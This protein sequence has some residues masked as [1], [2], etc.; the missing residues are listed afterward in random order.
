MEPS[1]PR[2]RPHLVVTTPPEISRAAAPYDQRRADGD[3]DV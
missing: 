1:L 3:V 2:A